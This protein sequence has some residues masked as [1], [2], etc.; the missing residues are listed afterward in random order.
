[1]TVAITLGS[2]AT[3]QGVTRYTAEYHDE[4]ARQHRVWSTA[5]TITLIGSAI[6]AL[7]VI[8]ASGL[9][10]RLLLHDSRYSAVFVA[11]APGLAPF[12]LNALLLAILNGRKD[13]RLYVMANV[14]GS[15]IGLAFTGALAGWLGLTGAMIALALNQSIAF[16]ATALLV[17]NKPWF[18]WRYIVG[19]IDPV[20]L[21]QLG[22]DAL[23]AVTSALAGPLAQTA[24]R[25]DLVSR[26]GL[27]SR[28]VGRD[29]PD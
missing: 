2:G 21:R 7:I 15:L 9:L 26:L 3:A 20:V 12:G 24:I 8:P 22:R 11:L 28:A 27:D 1:M 16:A 29:Q 17:R 4:E 19:R 10:A 5:G 18:R 13:T 23:M 14:A 25:Q 6:A